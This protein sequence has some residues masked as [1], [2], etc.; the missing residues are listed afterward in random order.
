MILLN[1]RRE[2]P[3]KGSGRKQQVEN[4]RQKTAGRKGRQK[5]ADRKQQVKNRRIE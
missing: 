3:E 5:R 4:S 1:N 2:K